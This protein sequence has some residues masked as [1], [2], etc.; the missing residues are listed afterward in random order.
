[1]N[2]FEVC[3]SVSCIDA[4]TAMGLKLHKNYR[5]T[6]W[7]LCPL[8]G[9]RGHPS[10]FL[11]S[12]R[13]WYCYGCHRGGHDA[14]SLYQAVCGME[15]LDA[16]FKCADD[17]GLHYDNERRDPNTVYVTARHLRTALQRKREE[18]QRE[19]A[20]QECDVD[21]TIQMMIHTNGMETCADDPTFYRLV[22]KRSEIQVMLDRLTT[23]N[24]DGVLLDLIK[25]YEEKRGAG[26]LK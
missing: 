13:G 5:G 18:I 7:T 11:S 19:L 24:D 9:E 4:A 22:E 12:D 8:H 23:T 1:M 2:V 17:F 16:A 20:N 21:D 15:P 26:C 10:M 6:A 14:V 3:R 25:D